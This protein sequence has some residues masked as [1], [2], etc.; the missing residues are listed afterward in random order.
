MPGLDSQHGV[1]V[2]RAQSFTGRL[3]ILGHVRTKAEMEWLVS[4]DRYVFEFPGPAAKMFLPPGYCAI[5]PYNQGDGSCQTDDI[6]AFGIYPNE[7]N[8]VVRP[9]GTAEDVDEGPRIRLAPPFFL[10]RKI[11]KKFVGAEIGTCYGAASVWDDRRNKAGYAFAVPTGHDMAY[12]DL[13]VDIKKLGALVVDKLRVLYRKLKDMS[14]PL[15]Y[16]GD[17]CARLE[18]TLSDYT[19]KRATEHVDEADVPEVDVH[20][21]LAEFVERECVPAEGECAV[22]AF[23]LPPATANPEDVLGKLYTIALERVAVAGSRH[24]WLTCGRDLKEVQTLLTSEDTVA[25][26]KQEWAKAYLELVESGADDKD[27]MDFLQKSVQ[28]LCAVLACC[29]AMNVP[30]PTGTTGWSRTKDGQFEFGDSSGIKRI[31]RTHMHGT[32]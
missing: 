13:V 28:Q 7:V 27:R 29:T 23:D 26:A 19:L 22:K 16:N 5:E 20:R 10:I 2:V 25:K 1:I 11:L 12:D 14:P 18:R 30:L 3:P 17:P 4:K 8:G 21:R 6:R 31:A 32:L 24:P 15:Q 9:D